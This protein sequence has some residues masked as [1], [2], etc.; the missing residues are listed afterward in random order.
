MLE[1][2]KAEPSLWKFAADN[3]VILV[4]PLTLLAYLRLVYLAWQHEKEARNQAEI[5]NTARELLTRM[6]SFLVTFEGMGKALLDMQSKYEDARGIL[7][8]TPHAQT[9]A[10]AAHKL[11]DLH[12][13]LESRKGK[14]IEKAACLKDLGEQE[15]QSSGAILI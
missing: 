8:D 7:V 3:N 14:R 12:V 5:V 4:T 1:A 6:N 15:D 11:I 13:K 9:I 2:L 10:K